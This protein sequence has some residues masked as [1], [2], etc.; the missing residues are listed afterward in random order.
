MKHPIDTNVKTH[1]EF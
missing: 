1:F